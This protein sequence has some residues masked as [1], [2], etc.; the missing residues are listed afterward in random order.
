MF[1]LSKEVIEDS[2]F[3]NDFIRDMLGVI[4]SYESTVNNKEGIKKMLTIEERL[5]ATKDTGTGLPPGAAVEVTPEELKQ[6]HKNMLGVRG[7]IRY[8]KPTQSELPFHDEWGVTTASFPEYTS[9][10]VKEEVDKVMKFSK[11][12]C[13][14]ISVDDINHPKHYTEHP[15][16]VECIDVTE[17]FEFNLG[18]VIK[19]VWR[20]DS[21]RDPLKDLRKAR[22]YLDREIKR[23]EAIENKGNS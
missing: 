17:H 11:D 18:N 15:S 12:L 14:D 21:K 19:Y 5:K 16:G 13:C 8:I 3:A 2:V 10:K 7:D 6:A 20:C 23:R 22:W 4:H 9:K 1:K